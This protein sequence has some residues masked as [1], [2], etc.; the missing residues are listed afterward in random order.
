M[1]EFRVRKYCVS[2]NCHQNV[3]YSDTLRGVQGRFL[4][5]QLSSSLGEYSIDR[6]KDITFCK[7]FTK[8]WMLDLW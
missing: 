4:Y 7:V 8:K 1:L 3:L 2:I 6:E 5:S